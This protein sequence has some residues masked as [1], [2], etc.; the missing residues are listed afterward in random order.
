MGRGSCSLK[1]TDAVSPVAGVLSVLIS[2]AAAALVLVLVV[3]PPGES[4]PR[5]APIFSI[6]VGSVS[7]KLLIVSASENADWARLSLRA[8]QGPLG[9]E[10]D[11]GGPNGEVHLAGTFT[12]ISAASAP[13]DAGQTLSLC[14]AVAGGSAMENVE[15][16]LRDDPSKQLIG[17]WTLSQVPPC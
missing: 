12:Q 4:T 11:S 13:M 14:S 17:A 9:F 15:V 1:E 16:A 7:G 6:D 5:T 10:I 3:D 2:L 8:S